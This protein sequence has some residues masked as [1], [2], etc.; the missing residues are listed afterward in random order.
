MSQ[1]QLRQPSLHALQTHA[2]TIGM[3]AG[4]LPRAGDV[5]AAA[6]AVRR[7]VDKLQLDWAAA[8]EVG[9]RAGRG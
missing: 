4:G 3:Q 5:A 9:G 1:L 2:A 8:K 6:A 7:R